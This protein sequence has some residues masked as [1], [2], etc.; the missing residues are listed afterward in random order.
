[1]AVLAFP[2]P[3][4]PDAAFHNAPAAEKN[5]KNPYEGAPSPRAKS[6]YQFRCGKC[7]GDNG[8]G[9]GNIPA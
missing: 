4:G 3:Q 1:M 7:H 9:S 5:L 6:M 2:G 8:E